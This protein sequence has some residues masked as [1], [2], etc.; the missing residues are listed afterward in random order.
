MTY[1]MT[2]SY[3]LLHN[4]VIYTLDK[5]LHSIWI[6]QLLTPSALCPDVECVASQAETPV[7]FILVYN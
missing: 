6:V 5:C 1:F 3:L 2:K 4:Y 7:R